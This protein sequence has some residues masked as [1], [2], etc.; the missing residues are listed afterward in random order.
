MLKFPILKLEAVRELLGVANLASK[1][2]HSSLFSFRD[3]MFFV[4]FSVKLNIQICKLNI[5]FNNPN[6]TTQIFSVFE[7]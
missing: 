4:V 7:I 6:M 3:M 5:K 2:D 1:Y